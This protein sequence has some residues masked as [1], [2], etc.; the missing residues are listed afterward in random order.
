MFLI[1]DYLFC[2]LMV[3]S[4]FSNNLATKSLNIINSDSNFKIIYCHVT[5]Y[6]RLILLEGEIYI[7][8][9]K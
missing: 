9:E 5:I 6:T 8:P 3:I 2:I 7:S 1:F 4:K